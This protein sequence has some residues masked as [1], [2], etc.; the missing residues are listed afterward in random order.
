MSLAVQAGHALARIRARY[1]SHPR[2]AAGLFDR[3]AFEAALV[4]LQRTRVLPASR[5][6]GGHAFV[7]ARDGP[8]NAG[9]DHFCVLLGLHYASYGDRQQPSVGMSIRG[10]QIQERCTTE[11]LAQNVGRERG[12]NS[13]VLLSVL[14]SAATRNGTCLGLQFTSGDLQRLGA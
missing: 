10:V 8:W 11:S 13:R 14:G 1:A 6:R 4:A 9:D 3:W 12:R 7:L 2:R 5:Q